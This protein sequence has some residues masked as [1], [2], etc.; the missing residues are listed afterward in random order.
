MSEKRAR[1]TKRQQAIRKK[2]VEQIV[3]KAQAL[4]VRRRELAQ[5]AER[6]LK[7]LTPVR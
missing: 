2:S 3:T 6:L 5:K 7:L 1:A 4:V